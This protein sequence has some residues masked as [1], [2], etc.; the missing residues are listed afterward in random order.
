MKFKD[1][2]TIILG[3]LVVILIC[4]V[5]DFVFNLGMNRYLFICFWLVVSFELGVGFCRYNID[6]KCICKSDE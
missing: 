1:L 3:V 6:D 5:L 4:Q 2:M